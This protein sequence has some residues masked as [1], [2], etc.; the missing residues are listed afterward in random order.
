MAT[1]TAADMLEKGTLTTLDGLRERLAQIE[2]LDEHIYPSSQQIRYQ[3]GADWASGPADEPCSVYL[4]IP[5]A[6]SR[7]QLTRQAVLEAAAAAKLPRGVTPWM[8]PNVLQMHLNWA[9]RGGLGEKDHKLLFHPRPAHTV[10]NPDG[11]DPISVPEQEPLALAMCRGTPNQFSSVQ[12]LEAA[13]GGIQAAYGSSDIL[14]DTGGAKFHADLE[15]TNMRLIVPERV[16]TMARTRTEDDTWSAGISITNS[17]IGVSH[18]GTSV[19]AYLFRWWCTNGC[20]DQLASTG[21]INRHTITDP[22]DAYAWARQSVDSALA[23]LEG[24]FD[25]VQAL[26]DIP[27]GGGEGSNNVRVSQVL[28]DLFAQNA[29]PQRERN[30]I[31]AQL[32]ELGGNLS[33]Y[34]IMQA[35]TFAANDETISPRTVDR[36]HELGGAVTHAHHDRC[37]TCHQL[38]PDDFVAMAAQAAA[39][40]AN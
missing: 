33:M 35:I 21:R 25:N 26:A 9:Y 8:D 14:V 24:L 5:G 11:G 16:R 2:P 20:T 30:R 22:N 17:L 29:I 6:D 39:G 28:R 23:G 34:D 13:V 7:Y 31:M 15:R 32:A 27:V 19:S 10:P 38:L 4:Q 40:N 36:L 1:I 12:L 37:G 3:V 18:P